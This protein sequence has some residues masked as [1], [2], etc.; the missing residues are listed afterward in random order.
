MTATEQLAAAL[1]ALLDAPAPCDCGIQ[2]CGVTP[3]RMDQIDAAEREA[4][5]ALARYDAE[6]ESK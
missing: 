6:K 2:G 1:R 5:E 3:C 4:R